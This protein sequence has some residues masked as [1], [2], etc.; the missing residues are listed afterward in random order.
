MGLAQNLSWAER[1]PKQ[2]LSSRTFL[3]REFAGWK[4]Q[5]SP[6][7]FKDAAAADPVNG[8]LLKEYGFRDFET[9]TYSRPDGRRL[10]VRAV[11]FEDASGALGAFTFYNTPQMLEEKI[12]DQGASLNRRV[13]FYKGD[14][15]V[16]AL[17]ERL[18]AMSAA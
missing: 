7:S 11:R 12:G 1:E 9:L 18:S 2:A 8:A 15:L 16:D 5:G 17:F 6:T 13:L 10:T 14:V 3:P 4:G